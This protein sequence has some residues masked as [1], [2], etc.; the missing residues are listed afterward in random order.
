MLSFLITDF[1][2][3]VMNL[4]HKDAYNI[5]YSILSGEN[6]I[7]LEFYSFKSAP[8]RLVK[9]F[10]RCQHI[11][12]IS[13]TVG[14]HSFR[15]FRVTKTVQKAKN[16]FTSVGFWALKSGKKYTTVVKEKW[17]YLNCRL[18]SALPWNQ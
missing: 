11:I 1:F 18:D 3:L 12:I 16:N 15:L 5:W 10:V 7:N 13:S 8:I 17:I 14:L 2:V 9:H 6:T 4:G